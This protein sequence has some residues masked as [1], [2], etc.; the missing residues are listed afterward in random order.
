MEEKKKFRLS[1]LSGFPFCFPSKIVS[2]E[3]ILKLLVL[4]KN[5]QQKHSKLSLKEIAEVTGDLIG[6]KTAEKTGTVS[7]SATTK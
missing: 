2:G 4:L 5:Q 1:I 7:K 3:H 6:S